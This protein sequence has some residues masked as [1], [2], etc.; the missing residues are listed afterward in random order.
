MCISFPSDDVYYHTHIRK[1][2]H[3]HLDCQIVEGFSLIEMEIL[4]MI[5]HSLECNWGKG[6]VEGH[7]YSRIVCEI[8]ARN[9][10]SRA[11]GGK[12]YTPTSKCTNSHSFCT[13]AVFHLFGGAVFG[14]LHK[15]PAHFFLVCLELFCI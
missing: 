8:V 3:A 14:D 15:C 13:N 11:G 4:R 5:N 9:C 10:T 1:E 2:T 12:L 6:D 7:L